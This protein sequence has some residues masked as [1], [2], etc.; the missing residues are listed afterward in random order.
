MILSRDDIEEIEQDLTSLC[1]LECTLCTRNYSH[2]DLPK[3]QKRNIDDVIKQLDTFTNL[4]RVYLAGQYSEPLLFPDIIKYLKYLKSRNIYV[5]LYSNASKLNIELWK[6]IGKILTDT[7]QVHFTICGSTQELHEK[8]RVNSKLENIL[9][10][11]KALKAI[12]NI[13]FCQFIRFGYNEM[14][15]ENV[16][17]FNFSNHY[18]VDSEG[19]RFKNDKKK[20]DTDTRPLEKRDRL[21][22]QLFKTIPKQ[23]KILCKSII[24][25]K[26]Y[27][28][29]YG[30]ISA[31][32]M[33][34]EYH[35]EEHFRDIF[36]YTDILDFKYPEC[37]LCEK[38][39]KCFIESMKLDFVC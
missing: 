14:D 9:K 26:V 28:N 20:P 2:F 17:K 39:T 29:V 31:C 16:K 11:V 24:D 21:I 12:K 27:I 38:R 18:T 5:E 6:N 23:G 7:D 30:N 1:D 25:K 36:D 8:Y 32:Y 33:N 4:K 35:P 13:D 37:G 10:N 19:D 22:K 34:A 15:E 3:P